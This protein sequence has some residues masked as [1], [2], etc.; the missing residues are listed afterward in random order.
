MGDAAPLRRDR[1]VIR[2][3]TL[4]RLISNGTTPTVYALAARFKVRRESI[5]RDLK[6]LQEVGYPLVGD[7]QGRL[8]RPRLAPEAKLTIPPPPLTRQEITA[9]LWAA[10]Q[11]QPTRAFRA[12]IET[13]LLK[14]QGYAP[15]KESTRGFQAGEVLENRPRGT[16]KSAQTEEWIHQCVEAALTHR[17]CLVEYQSPQRPKPT[18]F[19]FDPYRLLMVQ[20]GTYCLGK[21]PAYGDIITLALERI[22]A[23]THT[24]ES[25]TVDPAYDPKKYETEAFGVVWEKP[26]TVVIR[27]RAD[28]VPYVKERIWHPT[29]KFKDLPDGD[30]IM[31]FRAGGEFEITRWVL[32]W[33]SAARVLEPAALCQSIQMELQQA[34]E[35]Y[36]RGSEIS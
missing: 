9:L 17:R 18:R 24:E 5:Y 12:A 35:A 21:A 22:R 30:T 2:L 33:G 1:Q 6:V 7:A 4:L 31:T 34:K 29:Q 25:F 19:P 16:K 27:F 20:G 15:S 26:M 36:S 11:V 14:L 8:S 28:Q 13:A 23:F 3:L 10:K 32:G